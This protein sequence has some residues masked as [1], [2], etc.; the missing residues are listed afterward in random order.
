MGNVTLA[1]GLT[2]TDEDAIE[3]YGKTLDELDEQERG[4]TAAWA[5]MRDHAQACAWCEPFLPCDEFVRLSAMEAIAG[6][7]VVMEIVG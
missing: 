2:V 1:R 7:F 5:T 3:L 6:A 4:R